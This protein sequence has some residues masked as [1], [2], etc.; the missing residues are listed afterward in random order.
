MRCP[1]CG[2]RSDEERLCGLVMIGVDEV[3]WRRRHRYLTTVCDHVSGGVVWV[4]EGRSAA[5]LQGFFDLLGEEKVTIRAVSID[6][7][8]GYEKAVREAVPQAKVCFDPFH[9]VKL[10]SEA[11]DQVRRAEWNAKGKSKSE[12]GRW[13]K[14][15]RW[16]LLKAP[17]NRSERQDLILAEVER[18]NRRLYRAFLLKE[19]LRTLYRDVSA[20]RAGEQPASTSTPGSPG[21]R[22]RSS[23]RS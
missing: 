14:G 20:H 10:A 4:A 3:S 9:V 17:E 2:S 7:S 23:S 6:M 18:A 1:D 19:E 8:G 16:A 15:T 21:L 12:G 13:V 11:V 22:D 5:A